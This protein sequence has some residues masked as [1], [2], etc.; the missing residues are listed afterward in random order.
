MQFKR[1]LLADRRA[2]LGRAWQNDVESPAG[3]L[4]EP[5]DQVDH[6]TEE[7]ERSLAMRLRD[8]DAAKLQ[9]IE[10]ALA[11]IRDDTYG[12]CEACE[13]PISLKRLR[14]RTVS[15]LCA[16]CKELAERLEREYYH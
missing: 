7:Y 11:R 12:I 16:R 13:Q 3:E 15:M 9:E 4:D 14:A 10:L 5:M 6:A 8:R 2:L 1:Q